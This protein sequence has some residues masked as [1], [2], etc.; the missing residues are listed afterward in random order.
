M[1]PYKVFGCVILGSFLGVLVVVLFTDQ[2]LDWLG[3]D[4]DDL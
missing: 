4:P 2:I 3:I 1:N